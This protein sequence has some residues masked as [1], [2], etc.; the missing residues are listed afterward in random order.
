[1]TNA[2]QTRN[3]FIYAI[4]ILLSLCFILTVGSSVVKEPEGINTLRFGAQAHGI[5]IGAAVDALPLKEDV[6]YAQALAREF[7]IVT[8]EDAMKFASVHPARN[9]FNF[10][11]CQFDC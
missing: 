7:N 11:R 1:M 2:L 10:C 3:T 9:K 8:P 4:I 6:T 5:L